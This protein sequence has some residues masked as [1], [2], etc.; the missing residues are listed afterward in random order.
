MALSWQRPQLLATNLRHLGG[1][2]TPRNQ[3]QFQPTSMNYDHF[4][5][6]WSKTL[7]KFEHWSSMDRTQTMHRCCGSVPPQGCIGCLCLT[8]ASRIVVCSNT[9]ASKGSSLG[10]STTSTPFSQ[11]GMNCLL[12]PK[13]GCGPFLVT[14]QQCMDCKTKPQ[15]TV[16]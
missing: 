4:L 13:R 9:Q 1:S 14:T 12:A 7:L 3:R 6:A 16:N 15:C 2:I 11:L 5:S 10:T 8:T